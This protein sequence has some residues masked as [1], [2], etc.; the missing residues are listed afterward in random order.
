MPLT[1]EDLRNALFETL[2]D[3]RNKDKPG[4]LERAKVVCE[5]AGKIIETAKVEV[6]FINA[7]GGKGSG[8]IPDGATPRLPGGQN[9]PLAL[10]QRGRQ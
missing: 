3:V 2:Q 5:V 6:A 8:F 9:A 1:I 4:D 7:S 10:G